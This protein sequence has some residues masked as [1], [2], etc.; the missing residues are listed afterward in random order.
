[1]RAFSISDYM[2]DRNRA[3]DIDGDQSGKA[4]GSLPDV[5]NDG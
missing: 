4:A 5:W 1:M 2:K 3:V